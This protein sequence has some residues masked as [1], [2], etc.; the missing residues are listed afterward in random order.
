MQQTELKSPM[1]VRCFR[2]DRIALGNCGVG[3]VQSSGCG[4]QMK[5]E[6]SERQCLAPGMLLDLG[7]PAAFKKTVDFETQE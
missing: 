6:E 7:S 3:V 5:P 1:R 2:A 4:N